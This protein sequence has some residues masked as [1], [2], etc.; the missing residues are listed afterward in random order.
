MNTAAV[1]DKTVCYLFAFAELSVI[2]GKEIW[3]IQLENMICY[4][5]LEL[6]VWCCLWTTIL[7]NNSKN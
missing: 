5:K 3:E 1:L 6:L 2:N 4:L 7:R